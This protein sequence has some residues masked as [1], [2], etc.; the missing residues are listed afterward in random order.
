MFNA[1]ACCPVKP[2]R[3]S[4]GPVVPSPAVL[5]AEKQAFDEAVKIVLSLVPHSKV[6]VLQTPAADHSGDLP[7]FSMHCVVIRHQSK[8]GQTDL[9]S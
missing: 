8:D 1:P 7:D 2:L 6:S 4:F 9:H 3:W 5:A